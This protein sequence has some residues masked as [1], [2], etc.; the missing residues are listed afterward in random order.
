MGW[1]HQLSATYECS[2]YSFSAMHHAI[3][4]FLHAQQLLQT[5]MAAQTLKKLCQGGTE[6]TENNNE[7]PWTEELS[8]T[9]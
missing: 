4:K 6:D 7:P 2:R 1:Q 8:V 9:S 3:F 5:F